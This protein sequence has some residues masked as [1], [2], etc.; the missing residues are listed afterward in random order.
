MPSARLNGTQWFVNC[1]LINLIG[2]GGGTPTGFAKHPG[3]YDA[4][5]IGTSPYGFRK[6]RIPI[7]V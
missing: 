7:D 1:A 4:D 5:D 2:A 3:A 6:S